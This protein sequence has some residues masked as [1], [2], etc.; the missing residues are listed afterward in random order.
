MNRDSIPDNT[1]AM[2]QLNIQ[3]G[4]LGLSD[5]NQISYAA[6][7]ASYYEC[8][9]YTEK[10]IPRHILQHLPSYAEFT[11]SLQFV[12]DISGTPFSSIDD[13]N[14]LAKQDRSKNIQHSISA[15]LKMHNSKNTHRLFTKPTEIAWIVSL[16]NQTAGEWLEVCPKTSYHTLTN[17]E[18]EIALTLRLLLPQKLVVPNTRCTCST[19][20][21][22]VQIDVT[23]IHLCTGCN[24]D[25]ARNDTHSN[26]RD[27]LIKGLNYLGVRT[28]KEQTNVF[29]TV[30]P[31]NGNRPDITAINLPGTD[32]SHL[33]D[34][35]ITSPIPSCNPQSLTMAE[36]IKPL[37]AA[38][39]AKA[40]K[41]NKCLAA[42]HACNLEF[43]PIVF[44]ITGRM[45]DDTED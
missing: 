9:K 30:D 38:K 6:Y 33:L 11:T 7:I 41:N 5:S 13:I 23:G 36:A 24:H 34:V 39:I 22:E 26:V 10:I 18:F 35:T 21:S 45:H 29:R 37:R 15:L 42:A 43:S 4:G 32:R 19:P 12:Q 40:R 20:D 1:W 2:A 3:D 17:E 28:I 27:Q 16:Q 8:S 31:D 14:N 44:E 25:G